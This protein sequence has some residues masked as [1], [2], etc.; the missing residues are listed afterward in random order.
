MTL[1][2]PF[3]FEDNHVLVIDKPFGLLS[4]GDLSGDLDVLTLVKG[5]IRER[6]AK[7]GNIYLGLVHRLDRPVGGVMVLAK[8]SKAAGRLSK[9]FRE[10]HPKKIYRAKVSGLLKTSRGTLTHLLKK[11][12]QQRVTKVVGPDRDGK[13]AELRYRVLDSKDD[14]SLVEIELIT[15]FSHQIR[16][17]LSAIGH[18]IVGDR[19]YG[20]T[21]GMERG[22]IALM[23]H[24]ITFDHPVG[25][26]A[27]TVEA[28]LPDF[29]R[30]EG[31]PV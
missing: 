6:D 13:A 8:T 2:V 11:D 18:P 14:T 26:E 15:G 19:K 3:L 30:K 5:I 16:V 25:R 28:A 12:K 4:Q 10:R 24:R 22:R 9:Q 1:A 31:L 7:P 23:A 21:G 27:V 17:Q 20:S 29:L